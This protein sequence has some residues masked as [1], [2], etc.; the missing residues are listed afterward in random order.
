MSVILLLFLFLLSS[1]Y[2]LCAEKGLIPARLLP[3][4][5]R[6]K[7]AS[8][9]GASSQGTMSSSILVTGGAGYIG[10]HTVLQLLLGGYRAVVVDNL[11]NASEVALKRVQELA[12][13]KGS[14]LAFHQ[15]LLFALLSCQVC[16]FFLD[17]F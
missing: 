3:N 9:V 8:R 7:F 1:I 10:S 15:V 17:S 2:I 6:Y 4:F 5:L 14:N 16:F 11:D 12:G 13:D